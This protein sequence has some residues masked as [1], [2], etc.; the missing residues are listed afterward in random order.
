M[1]IKKLKTL[2]NSIQNLVGG[3][4]DIGRSIDDTDE[5][6]REILS[7]RLE[8]NIQKAEPYSLEKLRLQESLQLKHQERE[9]VKE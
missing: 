3:L 5:Q 1:T 9:K 8:N 4:F 6:I 2:D 7:R